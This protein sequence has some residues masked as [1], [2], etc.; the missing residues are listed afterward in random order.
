MAS[1]ADISMQDG[2]GSS[3]NAAFSVEENI[4]QLNSIDKKVVQLM[5]HTSTALNSLT[6]PALDVDE[7]TK[8]T[9][10]ELD[11][12]AQKETF[13]TATDSFLTTLHSVDVL[14]KRQIMSLEEAGIVNL[15]GSSRQEPGTAPKASL[16]PNGLGA[17]G[18]LDV[19]WLNSRSTRVERE[20]E[21]ELWDKA[22]GLLESED[23]R[24]K[25]E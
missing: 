12:T 24:M 22:K 19:G 4:Q 6:T 17:I 16:K 20:M 9:K 23:N 8:E 18:N 25:V 13:R 10:G 15:S 11:P 14:M 2:E 7:G 21:A 5:K 1:P 3:S